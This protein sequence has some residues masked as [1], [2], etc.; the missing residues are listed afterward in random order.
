MLSGSIPS[1]TAAA[2]TNI[3]KVDP[4]WRFAC[5]T[6]L[7]WLPEVPGVT[8]AIALIAPVAGSIET[9]AE[10]GSVGAESVSMIAFRAA[11]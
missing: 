1:S 11:T 2:S 5:A 10:A 7:N 3:L 8:A 4:A 6:R 9:R